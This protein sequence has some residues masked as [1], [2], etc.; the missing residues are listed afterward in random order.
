MFN[1][2][3]IKKI[4]F[5]FEPETAHTIAEFGLRALP[6][7]RMINNKMVE[8]NFVND[9]MLSQ[10]LF[11]TT[12]H[13]PIGLGAGFDKNGEIVSEMFLS[14]FGFTEIGTVTPKHQEGNFKPRL[15]R[16][17]QEKSLQNAMGFN[18]HGAYEV[19]QNLKKVYPYSV[20]IGASIGKNKIRHLIH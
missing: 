6:Y 1:Y 18:N 8:C 11:G 5:N 10:D 7:C 19:I 14:G 3:T 16:H 13:N 12:F 15:Y 9:S 4:M 20:P 2:E 17:I